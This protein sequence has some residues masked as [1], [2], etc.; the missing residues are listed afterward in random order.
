MAGAHGLAVDYPG[1]FPDAAGQLVQGLGRASLEGLTDQGAK[2]LGQGADVDQELRTGAD[3]LT[4]IGAQAAAGDQ[5][6]D[7]WMIDEGAAPGMQHAQHAQGGA[8]P[9][10]VLGQVLQRLGRGAE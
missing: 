8:E 10:G 2:S 1:L 3:P 5:I 6:M 9:F 7:V 4:L